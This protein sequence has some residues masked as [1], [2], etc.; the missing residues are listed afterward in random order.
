MLTPR[1]NSRI[2]IL[3][4]GVALGVY[5]PGLI[6]KRRLADHGVPSAIYVLENVIDEQRRSKIPQTKTAFHRNFAMALMAQKICGDISHTYDPALVATLL[7]DWHDQQVVQFCVFS[8]FWLPILRKYSQ[9]ISH[10]NPKIH[11]CLMDASISASWSPYVEE[12]KRY[13]YLAMFDFDAG[14]VNYTM[15]IAEP[16][17]PFAARKDRYVIHGGGW[18]MGT[19]K[20]KIASLQQNGLALDV[21]CYEP[22]D[23]ACME[24]GSR[25][26]LIDPSWKPWEPINGRYCF[27]PFGQVLPDQPVEFL[28][29][30]VRSGVYDLIVNSKA[31]IS[32]PGGATLLDSFSSCTPLLFLSETFGAYE[33][34]NAALWQSL[35]FG[36]RYEDWEEQGFSAVPLEAMHENILHYKSSGTVKALDKE[37]YDAARD[38]CAI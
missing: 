21:V 25:Y 6:L 12:L 31:I 3:C 33:A 8:G 34:K 9:L 14:S 2:A 16:P 27:P 5:V 37:I 36:M 23:F 11:L 38:R 24:A 35:G 28:A 29:G 18:G 7:R 22:D 17:V 4:S 13:H 15:E 19:Y 20:Q 10:Q 26:F 30:D 1:F 32:K